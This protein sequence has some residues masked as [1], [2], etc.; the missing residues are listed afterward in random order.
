MENPATWGEAERVVQGVFN[1]L[2]E[3]EANYRLNPATRRY[4]LSPARRITDALRKAGLLK[5]DKPPSL[6]DNELPGMWSAADF[7]G[8]NDDA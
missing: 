4:G 8:G 7:T 2:T 5:E 3:E 1:K 6:N